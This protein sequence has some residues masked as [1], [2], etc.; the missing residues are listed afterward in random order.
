MFDDY[1][2]LWGLVPDGVAFFTPRAGLLPVRRGGAPAMLKVA[3][4]PEEMHGGLLMDWWD[5]SGAARV[6]AMSGPALLLERALGERSLTHYARNG[7][8]DE[9]TRII[10]EV[11]GKLHAPRAKPLPEGLVPLDIW[12]EA[13]APMAASVGGVLVRCAK[14]AQTL[15]PNQREIWPL[16]GDVHHDNVLDFGSRGWLVIDPKRLIGDRGFDYANLFCNPDM[17]EPWHRVAV[18]PERFRSR[19][20]IVAENARLERARLLEWIIAYTGLSAAW[21]IG[22]GLSAEVDLRVA[23]LALAELDR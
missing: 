17:E 11:V 13:L 21:C 23:E 8:D 10:C 7:R 12:F 9:A 22:D 4:E 18:L 16:H 19:L 15:L 14:I 2:T 6:L 20:A 3:T 1:L 5:G